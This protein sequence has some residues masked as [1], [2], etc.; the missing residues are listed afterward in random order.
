MSNLIVLIFAMSTFMWYLIDKFKQIWA[1]VSWGRWITITVS[2]IFAFGLA[3]GFELDLVYALGLMEEVTIAG[4][5]LT[6]L[7]LM[8]GSSAVAE[9]MEKIQGTHVE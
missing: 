2:A 4:K 6:A 8:S 9:V 3:I 1:N 7:I 5:I